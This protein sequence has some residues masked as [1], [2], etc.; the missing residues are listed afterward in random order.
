MNITPFEDID[1]TP[2]PDP[3]YSPQHSNSTV[4]D[5]DNDDKDFDFYIAS[6]SDLLSGPLLHPPPTYLPTY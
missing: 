3:P 5:D 6:G 1:I 2:P 4:I